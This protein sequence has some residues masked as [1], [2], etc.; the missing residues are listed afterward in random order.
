MR[1]TQACGNLRLVQ[2][3][4]S[5][6]AQI[7]ADLEQLRIGASVWVTQKPAQV[8]GLLEAMLPR[9]GSQA[10]QMV[11]AAN[12]A[13]GLTRGTTWGAE[14]WFTGPWAMAHAVKAYLTTFRR[15]SAGESPVSAKMVRGRA[16]GRVVVDVFPTTGEERLLFNGFSAEIWMPIGMTAEQVRDRAARSWRGEPVAP[17]V[18]LVLGAGNVAAITFLD[19]MYRLL[20]DRNAVMVKMN[21]VNDYLEPYL[22]AIF[23]DFIDLDLV[24]FASGGVEVGEALVDHPNIDEIHL[25]G[26][27]AT[28]DAI[29]WGAGAAGE[30]AKSR[31][32]QRIHKPVTSELG[33]VSPFIVVPG[34]WSEADL[35]YQAEHFLTSNLNNS[36]HNCICSQVLVL[37]A[38]WAQADEFITAI[39]KVASTLSMREPYYPKAKE[40]LYALAA[41]ADAQPIGSGVSHFIDLGI[42][43]DTTG[44]V[45]INQELF[46]SGFAV[47][48]LTSNSVEDFL[49]RAVRLAN[50][51]LPGTLGATLV[52]DPKT[53][54]RERLAVARA[55]SDLRYGNVGLNIWSAMS[56]LL[57]YTPWGAYPGH[58]A[59]DIGSGI[60]TVHNSYLLQDPEKV[61][62]EG[63]FRP[64]PRSLANGEGSLSPKLPLFVGH[65]HAWLMASAL[66]RR[67]VS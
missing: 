9:I 60:G 39:R 31:G 17:R 67:A 51:V 62:V 21:P 24:R 32:E 41:R 52:V 25:T 44:E 66:T 20:N 2:L 19:V 28:F 34:L 57:A 4:E 11:D 35:T 23:A 16:D 38:N 56:F 22:R 15:L 40:R 30:A 37:D 10:E 61:V 18:A 13:K 43:P 47:L 49:M 46:A 12:L 53:H 6:R 63:P 50:E 26:S 59:K 42:D 36:G 14:D 27:S 3:N 1:P 8:V 5:K 55:L 65:K 58:T 45:M 54:K 33:G 7:D 64:F 48:R 29:V